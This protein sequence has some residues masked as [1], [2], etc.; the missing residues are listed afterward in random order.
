MRKKEDEEWKIIYDQPDIIIWRRNINLAEV[1]HSVPNSKVDY[2]LYE[3]KVLGR[4][5][6]INAIEFFQT[7]IDLKYRQEWFDIFYYEI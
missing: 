4:I 3:Y 5:D 7:Q 6:D 2:D 1:D